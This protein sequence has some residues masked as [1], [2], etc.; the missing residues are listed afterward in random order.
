MIMY[1]DAVFSEKREGDDVAYI[2]FY[3]HEARISQQERKIKRLTM[4]TI[5]A[6]IM[7][8]LSNFMWF[9]LRR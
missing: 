2:P 6:V 4:A 1:D 5:S 7:L 8:V 9:L 3:I